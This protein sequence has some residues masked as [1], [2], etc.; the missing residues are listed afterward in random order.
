MV[1]VGGSCC[2]IASACAHFSFRFFMRVLLRG[3]QN[4]VLLL[5][6]TTFSCPGIISASLQQALLPSLVV[7]VAKC[8]PTA[9]RD[10][11]GSTATLGLCVLRTTKCNTVGLTCG[12]PSDCWARPLS[13][14]GREQGG[15]GLCGG[16]MGKRRH[17]EGRKGSRP[18]LGV[19]VEPGADPQLLA[20]L[21]A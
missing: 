7:L 18:D 19:V 16:D 21:Q 17:E 13:L 6:L 9:L 10:P 20:L 11:S 2:D 1:P 15:R 3:G 14:A 4:H 8:F 5:A 12:T